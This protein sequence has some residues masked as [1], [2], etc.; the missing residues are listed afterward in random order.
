MERKEERLVVACGTARR[1]GSQY[2]D[3]VCSRLEDGDLID[4]EV[5]R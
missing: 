4:I 1:E 2:C 5:N 3:L